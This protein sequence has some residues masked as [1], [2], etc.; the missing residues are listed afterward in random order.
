MHVRYAAINEGR[1]KIKES[2]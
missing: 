1:K 2:N